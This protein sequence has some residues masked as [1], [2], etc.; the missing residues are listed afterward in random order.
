MVVKSGEV[1]SGN[2]HNQPSRTGDG[3][4]PYV[5]QRVQRAK[6]EVD[7]P[8]WL[9]KEADMSDYVNPFEITEE[10]LDMMT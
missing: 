9:K 3:A 10:E 8:R 4:V 1:Q 5:Q 7:G 6:W 2:P